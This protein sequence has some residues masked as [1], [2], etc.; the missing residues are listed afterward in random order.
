[1]PEGPVE[2]F[3]ETQ[4]LPA[5]QVIHVPTISHGDQG[6]VH[7]DSYGT[8]YSRFL[9]VLPANWLSK[10]GLVTKR[11]WAYV[12]NSKPDPFNAGGGFA[13]G[14]YDGVR[15]LILSGEQEDAIRV[16]ARNRTV[17]IPQIYLFPDIPSSKGQ[18]VVVI[19]DD[20]AGEIFVT[21]E[22]DGNGVFP[23]VR[24]GRGNRMNPVCRVEQKRLALCDSK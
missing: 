4:P 13:S 19:S 7:V 12:R 11:I 22:P 9:T 21:R 1:M 8:T 20:R 16:H 14:E 17:T 24:P 10:H 15:V 23:L 18:H 3:P 6:I 5:L 2:D